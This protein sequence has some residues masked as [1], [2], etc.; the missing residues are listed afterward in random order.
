MP[1]PV[2]V[3]QGGNLNDMVE[4]LRRLGALPPS[5]SPEADRFVFA[6]PLLE[7]IDETLFSAS[8]REAS[9]TYPLDRLV[10]ARYARRLL[11]VVRNTHDQALT[12]QVVGGDSSQAGATSS[13]IS[14]G[15]SVSVA[16]STGR[17]SLGI[18]LDIT[19]HP[20]L[21]LTLATPAAAPTSGNVVV[22]AYGLRDFIPR[23][24]S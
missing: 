16:A 4:R 23:K 8:L 15:G 18:K 17:I 1:Q 2:D 12:V 7:A 11:F 13:L 9:T 14:V 20:Y 22:R 3:L 10:D 19:A 6:I 21:G 5:D 24:S